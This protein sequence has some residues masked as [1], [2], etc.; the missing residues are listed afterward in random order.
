MSIETL[1]AEMK[2]TAA[3]PAPAVPCA[4]KPKKRK[5][6]GKIIGYTILIFY[7]LFHITGVDD[8]FV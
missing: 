2:G 4:A 8:D 7:C 3:Q 5:V 1:Q 6:V